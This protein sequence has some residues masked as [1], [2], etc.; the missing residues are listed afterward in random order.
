MANKELLQQLAGLFL[1][2]KEGDRL[3][4]TRDLA[5][6][7]GMSVG[8]ISNALD[9][10]EDARA[11]R[12]ETR[13][14]Q[15]SFL[16]ERSVG[17]LW[18][19]ASS[20]P[21]VLGLTLVSNPHLEGLATALKQ[22]LRRSGIEAYLVFIRGSHTRLAALREGRCHA[23]VISCFAADE[24]CGNAE[25]ILFRLPAGSF[26]SGNSVFLSKTQHEAPGRLRVAIDRDS[27]DQTRITELE[28]AG[29]D[30]ELRPAILPQ[31]LRLLG[32]GQVDA[33]VVT[34]EDMQPHLSQAITQ[35]PLSSSVRS[36]LDERD[37]AAAIVVR[38]S[39]TE[40]GGSLQAAVNVDELMGIQH[41][42][43]EGRRIAEY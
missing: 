30:V 32:M 39:A 21:M 1:S 33:A 34:S 41:A 4:S 38:S 28:F 29:Q 2:L 6:L 40:V 22:V 36:F 35:V 16:G 15:G 42:V 13:G 5:G 26:S 8:S 20:S 17:Q 11:V 19:A 25:S 23:V 18:T 9:T 10:L 27:Y 37:T 7:Y 24:L 31:M 3:P 43:V 14:R 12:I